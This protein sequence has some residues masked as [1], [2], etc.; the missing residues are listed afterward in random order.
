MTR[1]KMFFDKDKETQWLNDM[2][3]QGWA[4]KSFFAGFYTFEACEKGQYRYQIDFVDKLC[5]VSDD[6]RGFMTDAG[7]EVV[8]TWGFWVYLRKPARDGEFLLYT[9]VD[10]QIGHYTKIQRMLKIVTIFELLCLFLEILSAT[11]LNNPLF[12]VF[13]FLLMAIVIACVRITCHTKDI[14][15]ELK[16]RKTGIAGTRKRK[17][18]IWLGIGMLLNSISLLIPEASPVY[19]YKLWLQIP[20]LVMI[21]Y[22]AY[23]STR[24]RSEE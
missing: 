1:F 21:L 11:R 22:G 15:A 19:R 13:V 6:Y 24:D 10:S 23:E 7:I 17:V 9:D 3:D 4:M 18:S 16:E 2:A 12:Y 5:N 8:Q 14:I 20:A